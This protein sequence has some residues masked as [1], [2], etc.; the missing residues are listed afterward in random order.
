MFPSKVRNLTCAQLEYC[1]QRANFS[2]WVEEN[3]IV[4][5][6]LACARYTVYDRNCCLNDMR[7]DIEY[8]TKTKQKH[9][10]SACIHYMM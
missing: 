7:F 9:P 10:E 3:E 5:S 4:T 1:V 2:Q 8:I 6:W